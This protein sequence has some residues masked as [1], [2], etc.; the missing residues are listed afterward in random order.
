MFSKNTEQLTIQR[1]F[2]EPFLLKM[3]NRNIQISLDKHLL[4]RRTINHPG[5][6]LRNLLCKSLVQITLK[7]NA[8]NSY[9]FKKHKVP[10]YPQSVKQ[11]TIQ[12]FLL[13]FF[14]FSFPLR[15]TFFRVQNPTEPLRNPFPYSILYS[16]YQYYESTCLEKVFLCGSLDS[17][18][19]W[20]PL[21]QGNTVE[22]FQMEPNTLKGGCFTHLLKRCYL[23]YSRCLNI[24]ALAQTLL[25]AL[26]HSVLAK[27][28]SYRILLIFRTSGLSLKVVCC[29]PDLLTVS[30]HPTCL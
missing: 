3:H 28:S 2:K 23:F 20:N 1:T 17:G 18:F 14:D 11:L 5:K 9:S 30:L 19:I 13:H 24:P 8:E 26:P 12:I 4:E 7:I 22:G 29:L 6:P 15:S 27:A 10:F 16:T 25:A 21:S